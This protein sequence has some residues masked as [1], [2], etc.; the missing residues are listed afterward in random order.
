MKPLLLV[1]ARNEIDTLPRLLRS[2]AGKVS[3][4]IIAD[5]G[6]D[7]GTREWCQSAAPHEILGCDVTTYTDPWID[8]ATNRNRLLDRARLGLNTPTW[9]LCADAD[10]EFFGELPAVLWSRMQCSAGG[11]LVDGYY[12]RVRGFN[13]DVSHTVL[14]DAYSWEWAGKVHEGLYRR[15]GLNNRT[16]LAWDEG[17]FIRH[18]DSAPRPYRDDVRTLKEVV[19]REPENYRA[20]YYLGR[21]YFDTGDYL[22]ALI[23]FGERAEKVVSW[24]EER[25]HARYMAAYAYE[26]ISIEDKVALLGVVGMYLEAY[27]ERPDRP[28]PLYRLSGV[29]RHLGMHKIA[30]TLIS[31]HKRNQRVTPMD[32]LLFTTAWKDQWG[33]ELEL[34]ILAWYVRSPMDSVHQFGRL[35]HPEL[36]D[37]VKETIRANVLLAKPL[38]GKAKSAWNAVARKCG[39]ADNMLD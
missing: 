28:E 17:W 9:V 19:K 6:S 24:E 21:S 37:W 38:A 25:W 8:Y 12:M 33:F 23:T 4:A 36:P 18:N 39:I 20:L 29:L 32:D 10:W 15:P 31:E 13:V 3:A 30:W 26:M 27:N 35:W 7:D 2:L 22:N 14:Y 16:I 11:T 1:I 5:T 34:A